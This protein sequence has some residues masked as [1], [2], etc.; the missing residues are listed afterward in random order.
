[1]VALSVDDDPSTVRNA[2]RRGF[3]GYLT[4]DSSS[5]GFI[6]SLRAIT[7]GKSVFRHRLVS[8]QRRTPSGVRDVALLA[9][10]LTDRE[11]EV[12][13]LI[14]QGVQ[15]RAIAETLGVRLNTVR[16]HVQS[17]LT[18]LQVHSRLEAAAFALQHRL[19][20]PGRV[21]SEESPVSRHP[22]A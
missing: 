21:A 16:S 10:Q 22:H 9:N 2:M 3:T 7:E 4:K 17:I 11:R 12:L 20:E 13:S 8:S 1:V 18:K 6:S 14:A 19:V 5:E 15:S